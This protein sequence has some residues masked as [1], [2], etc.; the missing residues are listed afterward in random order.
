MLQHVDQAD[1][2]EPGVPYGIVLTYLEQV[3]YRHGY[4]FFVG[5]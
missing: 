4:G 1:G 2:R 5:Y 3:Y